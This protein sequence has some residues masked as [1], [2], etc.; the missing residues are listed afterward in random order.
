MGFTWTPLPRGNRIA[1]VT[2]SGAQAIMSI[3]AATRRGLEPAEFSPAT[4][5]RLAAV[6]ATDGKSKNPIDIFPDMMV[7][8]FEKLIR[9]VL[10]ALF[11]DDGVNGIILISFAQDKPDMNRPLADTSNMYRNKPLFVSL[12]GTQE[13]V[14]ANADYLLEHKIPFYLYPEA[15]VTVFANMWRYAW[16]HRVS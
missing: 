5:E 3:D 13:D 1:V 9:Q 4:R 10:S 8:G 11:E 16:N 7:H 12:M 6:I 15:A 14:R 2:Y